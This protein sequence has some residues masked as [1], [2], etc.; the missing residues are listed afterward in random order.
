MFSKEQLF[1]AF[2]YTAKKSLVFRYKGDPPFDSETHHVFVILYRA[3]ESGE[4]FLVNGSSKYDKK[5]SILY[6]MGRNPEDTLVCIEG[7]KYNFFP[8]KTAIDC[9]TV[10]EINLESLV[11][12]D[13]EYISDCSIE[14]DDMD[15]IIFGIKNSDSVPGRIK[16]LID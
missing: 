16:E 9:N 14:E 1:E 11:L 12:E 4:L 5:Y 8:L 10:H 7:G 13:F 3:P 6:K 2:K 15:K